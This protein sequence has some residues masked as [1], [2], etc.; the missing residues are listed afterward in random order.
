MYAPDFSNDTATDEEYEYGTPDTDPFHFVW[1]ITSYVRKGANSLK[2]ESNPRFN[3][4]LRLRDVIVEMGDPV[5]L[6]KINAN[7]VDESF[8]LTGNA[9][10]DPSLN[11][12]TNK[13]AAGSVEPSPTGL[14]PVYVPKGYPDIPSSIE[15]S[16]TGNIRFKI[17]QRSFNV[18]SRTSLPEGK[19]NDDVKIDD[20]WSRLPRGETV[21]AKWEGA[22][23]K[24][25]RKVTLFVDHI[26]VADTIRNTGNQLVGVMF[27]NRLELPEK[28]KGTLIAGQAVKKHLK[29]RS[30]PAH[31]TAIAEFDN[32][33][34]G[35]VAEDDIF[36]I[37]A[38]SFAKEGAIGVSDPKLGIAPG[39]AHTLEWSIYMVP[40]GDYWDFIN[41]IRR[42][43][44]SNATLKGPSKWVVP[45]SVPA[46]ADQ[47]ASW[48][49]KASMIVLCNPTVTK[50]EA[51]QEGD[52][53]VI[54]QH[55]TALLM[56]KTWSEQARNAARRIKEADPEAEAF[57]YLHPNACTEPG[58]E[59]LY[60]DSRALNLKGTISKTAYIKPPSSLS[61]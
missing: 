2:I 47:F 30:S 28:P 61:A 34:I 52:E 26:S 56:C 45:L 7:K 20:T 53:K 31:P 24:V 8:G 25:E 22:D 46:K 60:Q 1:D 55:G 42:N 27:E 51:R 36:R 44:G 11:I 21:I 18:H 58:H 14:L 10:W 38:E 59:Q 16:S 57:V 43:W 5:S 50:Q 17:G 54:L 39:K 33:V 15:V 41:A 9:G 37:H 13:Q 23:Y 12:N 4:S 29:H 3:F 35:L 49:Q 32:L 19:W 40:N 6:K 48:A